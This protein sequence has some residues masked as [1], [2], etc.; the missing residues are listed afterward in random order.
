[1]WFTLKDKYLSVIVKHNDILHQICTYY[2]PKQGNKCNALRRI[3]MFEILGSIATV[4]GFRRTYQKLN[5]YLILQN[6]EEIVLTI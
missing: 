1:M 6:C 2:H 5:H 3:W 4:I